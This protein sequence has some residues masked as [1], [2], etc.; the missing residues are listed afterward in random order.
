MG[1]GRRID[2][3]R[4]ERGVMF[5]WWGR[6]LIQFYNDAYRPILGSSKP[7]PGH[8]SACRASMATRSPA[9]RG[10]R[11]LAAGRSAHRCWSCATSASRRS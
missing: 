1:L 2:A 3:V 5:L 6:E 10:P 7:A 11:P 8:G 4:I 9:G